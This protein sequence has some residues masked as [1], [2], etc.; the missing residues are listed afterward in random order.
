MPK[1]PSR[2]VVNTPP[3]RQRQLSQQTKG[4]ES[5]QAASDLEV[6][7][8]S[9]VLWQTPTASGAGRVLET[10][11]H[12]QAGKHPEVMDNVTRISSL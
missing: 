5:K 1:F 9:M 3:C 4:G 10:D 7:A 12:R 8:S 6:A 2:F 11:G